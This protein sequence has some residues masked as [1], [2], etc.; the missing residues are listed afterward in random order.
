MVKNALKM[1]MEKA[2]QPVLDQILKASGFDEKGNGS[3]KGF[4]LEQI[5]QYKNRL[6]K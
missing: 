3:F 5:E 2:L 6:P 4:T 1:R